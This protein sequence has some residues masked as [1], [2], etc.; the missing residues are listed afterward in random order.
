MRNVLTLG[1]LEWVDITSAE[2]ANVEGRKMHHAVYQYFVH[3]ERKSVASGSAEATYYSLRSV[4]TG[5]PVVT[6]RVGAPGGA[7]PGMN[8]RA[9][10]VGHDN[11][12]PYPQYGQQIKALGD[13]LGVSLDDGYPY[14][15]SVVIQDDKSSDDSSFQPF[16]PEN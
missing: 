6:A 5:E 15:S 7:I 14:G 11:Y 13:H 12:D 9:L 2:E 1:N 8:G 4:E 3:D 10:I 16:F